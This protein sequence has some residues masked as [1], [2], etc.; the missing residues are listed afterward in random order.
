[1][2]VRTGFMMTL[3]RRDDRAETEPPRLSGFERV[4][5]RNLPAVLVF[6]LYTKTDEDAIRPTNVVDPHADIEKDA[7][8]KS[9]Q[10]T[11]SSKKSNHVELV[12]TSKTFCRKDVAGP[13]R[14]G[15]PQEDYPFCWFSDWPQQDVSLNMSPPT[16]GRFGRAMTRT[17]EPSFA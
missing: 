13:F 5:F 15:V 4:R 8:S 10:R 3:E 2:S 17:H 16:C 12:Q 11:G 9:S 14:L 1:M 6:E 7:S